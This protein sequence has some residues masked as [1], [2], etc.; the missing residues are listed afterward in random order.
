[1][2]RYELPTD[3]PA[4]E[5]TREQRMRNRKPRF[6]LYE[7]QRMSIRELRELGERLRVPMNRIVEKHELIQKLVS[8]GKIDIIAAPEPVEYPL[9][10]LRAMGVGQLK[11][12]MAN[13]GVF[14]DPVD[15]VE[16]EDMIHIFV[17]S[18][19]LVILAEVETDMPGSDNY[20]A[21]DE[22]P[23]TEDAGTQ[24]RPVLDRNGGTKSRSFQKPV[25]TTVGED[26]DDDESDDNVHSSVRIRSGSQ[27]SPLDNDSF[28]QSH[29]LMEEIPLE[30]N[31]KRS[32]ISSSANMN[33]MVENSSSR[34]Q[35]Q[36]VDDAADDGN[37][38]LHSLSSSDNF[39]NVDTLQD[40]S[41]ARANYRQ[42]DNAEEDG[43]DV[44]M[45]DA[46]EEVETADYAEEDGGDLDMLDAAEDIDSAFPRIVGRHATSTR[47]DDVS[48]VDEYASTTAEDSRF[49]ERSI[50]DLQALARE[51]R[52]DITDCIERSEIIHRLVLASGRSDPQLEP[53]DFSNWSVSELRALARE[54]HVNLSNCK[55]RHDM[56]ESL[57]EAAN[58]RPRVADYL[59]ALM[60]LAR[61]TVPQLRAVAREWQ[62]NV[63]DCLEKEEMIHRLVIAGG[64]AS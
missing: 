34:G 44:E 61:L 33:A 48:L 51:L 47:S 3:N 2:C 27:G 37:A 23:S 4:Y 21:Q 1:M 46:T 64:P 56:I 50:A 28:P 55:D 12:C 32:F 41:R 19:R 57:V 8:S 30:N 15:V 6:A 26:S 39:S 24:M 45:L 42:L 17:N 9:S 29:P 5:K 63:H 20:A 35:E 11:R 52:V 60:P 25:V 14:F 49:Q 22:M 16:K 59:S 53:T 36:G 7:L 43:D 10:L 58:L 18:G 54:V 40:D 31:A 62:V 38:Q 13:A